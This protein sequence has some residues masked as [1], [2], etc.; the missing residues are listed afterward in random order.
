M[1]FSAFFGCFLKKSLNVGFFLQV[2]WY[3]GLPDGH[4][5]N[6]FKM[7]SFPAFVIDFIVEF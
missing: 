3:P 6:L 5:E 7:L 4:I 2:K 1:T